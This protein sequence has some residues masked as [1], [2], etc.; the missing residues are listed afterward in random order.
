MNP[1][2]YNV[3]LKTKGDNKRKM[4]ASFADRTDAV[5]FAFAESDGRYDSPE[6]TLIALDIDRKVFRKYNQGCNA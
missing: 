3:Y 1:C 5:N 4:L 2:Q 6:Y